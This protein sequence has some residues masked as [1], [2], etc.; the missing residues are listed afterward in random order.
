MSKC[1]KD[2]Y[3]LPISI[4]IWVDGCTGKPAWI[5]ARSAEGKKEKKKKKPLWLLGKAEVP[6]KRTTFYYFGVEL[7]SKTDVRQGGR[8][9]SVG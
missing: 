9:Q 7:Y 3:H 6:L 1:K 2:W 4:V 8:Q 5:K